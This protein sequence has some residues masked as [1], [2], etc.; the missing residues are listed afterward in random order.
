MEKFY[1]T[2]PIYYVNAE[3]HIGH[4]YTTIFADFLFRLHKLRG[5]D[6]FF[7]TGT[8]EHGDKIMQA[9]QAKNTTPQEYADH[10]SA[11]FKKTWVDIGIQFQDYIRTT[12]ERHTS[13]VRSILQKVYDNG[14]IYFGS[15]GGFYCV[16]C[17][18]FFTE[19][20][21]VGGKCPDHNKKL[22]FIEEK[23]YF[24]KMSKYQDW[25]INHID[26][27]PDF[28][29]PERYKNEVLAMLKHDALEDLCISR[30]KSRLSW[31][32]T[33]PFDD[34][35]VTYVWFDALINYVSGI[36]WPDGER[37]KNYWPAAQH[38]IAKDIVKPHGIFWPTMLKSAGIEP[39]R[40]LN[41]HGYW[42]M[43]DAKMSKS[44]GNVVTPVEL[45][46]KF[47]NDQV[48]YFF[49]RE[50]TFGEDAKFNEDTIVNRINFDLANDLGNLVKR[51][52]DM[53]T[54]FFNGA[55]P[56]FNQSDAGNRDE[57]RSRCMKAIQD[58]ISYSSNLQTSIGI[59]KLWEYVRYLNKYIDENK[60]WQLAKEGKNL[61]LSS[62]LRNLLESIYSIAVIL[63]PIFIEKSNIIIESLGALDKPRTIDA[64]WKLNL[65]DEGK[66]IGPLGI[67]FPRIEKAEKAA[68]QTKT[69]LQATLQKEGDKNLESDG[70]ID[71]QEFTKVKI[72][73]SQILEA[74]RIEGSDKLLQL[75]V[76][77]GGDTRTI[78]AGIA[79]HY[80]PEYLINKKILLVANLKPATIFKRTSNGM[81][82]AA[83]K[84][85][86]E[87]P[88]LIEVDGAIPV[89]ARLG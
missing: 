7:L 85:K 32:I 84:D 4:A 14:D 34:K 63:S 78:I 25:L 51:S 10:I 20:E 50:M 28:I 47:G 19:K 88:V 37:F 55:I 15:Y 66:L 59:E 75:K 11:I 40:N 53:V 22:Q 44:I 46:R 18:R 64:L 89:G 72:I 29:R 13:V 48:R 80:T 56:A 82:L 39:Y 12:E 9:A 35:F 76:D 57:L 67:L 73:V 62:I 1:I 68:A 54:K 86:N 26:N 27:N 77:T 23:N 5:Y 61:L 69:E 65:L 41:V 38:L 71:I 83:K 21:M 8:D 52:L 87:K 43:D 3:P 30:P 33:L 81:L 70:L 79:L 36:G 31:G 16:G 42:N 74:E 49:L 17:E 58:Y 45:V 2:T 24:F 60:P 6:S